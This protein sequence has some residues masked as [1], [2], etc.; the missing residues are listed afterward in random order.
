MLFQL[1]HL[2]LELRLAKS[3]HSQPTTY[4]IGTRNASHGASQKMIAS[5]KVT[6]KAENRWT[7]IVKRF[8]ST[9]V[10]YREG[11]NIASRRIIEDEL[12][13]LIR[14]WIKLLPAALKEDA[15]AD[16][17]DMFTREQ[18]IVDQGLKIQEIFKE[19]L[20]KN[21]IPQVEEQVA[22]KYRTL[23][24]QDQQERKTCRVDEAQEASNPTTFQTRPQAFG[25]SRKR[26]PLDD[27]QNMI[28]AVH[29][30]KS[31]GE[32]IADSILS[33][34]EIVNTLTQANITPLLTQEKAITIQ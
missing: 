19:T 25:R 12:P 1:L 33:L 16:L 17:R 21:V 5:S 9:C 13:E 18:S 27:V 6:E 20:M 34:D 26:I 23:Y 29:E 31:E 32:E 14:A 7:L 3:G 10:L 24:L 4:K 8:R 15:K 30:Q 11:C 2:G 28:D 22:A